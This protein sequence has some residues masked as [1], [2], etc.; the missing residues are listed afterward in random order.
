VGDVDDHAVQMAAAVRRDDGA[1]GVHDPKDAAAGACEAILEVLALSIREP[2]ER[3]RDPLPID[4]LD[5]RGGEVR[6]LEPLLRAVPRE[7]PAAVT[8]VHQPALGGVG[9]P[10]DGVEA[11]EEARQIEL[12]LTGAGG[13]P[14]HRRVLPAASDA[15][16][17]M[18][19]A[20]LPRLDTC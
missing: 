15:R 9:S 13:H 7:G 10:D 12:W 18:A 8:H 3:P 6:R 20:S 1:H 14:S 17:A 4:R 2:I 19:K 5:E 16:P 11:V